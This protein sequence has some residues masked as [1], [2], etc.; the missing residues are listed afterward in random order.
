VSIEANAGID[1]T[2]PEGSTVLLKGSGWYNVGSEENKKT[3]L[4][5]WV[6]IV[7]MTH[8]FNGL[9]SLSHVCFCGQFLIRSSQQGSIQ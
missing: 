1:Q 3:C 4:V 8:D 2:V 5:E 6:R 7:K 9:P